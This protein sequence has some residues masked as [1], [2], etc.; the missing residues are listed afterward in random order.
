MNYK[1]IKI[2]AKRLIDFFGGATAMSDKFNQFGFESL[3]RDAI[4]KWAERD[5]I[6]I[7]RWLEAEHIAI[8]EG[9]YV[10]MRKAC[11]QFTFPS[12]NPSSVEEQQ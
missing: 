12:R 8:K 9:S 11:I 5:S 6:P 3:N 2:N 4:Y 10:D 7:D 1:R